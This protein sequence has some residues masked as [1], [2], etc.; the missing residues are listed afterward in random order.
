MSIQ[1]PP[2]T[3]VPCLPSRSLS[4]F[5][6]NGRTR[7]LTCSTSLWGF[8]AGDGERSAAGGGEVASSTGSDVRLGCGFPS[9]LCSKGSKHTGKEESLRN[10]KSERTMLTIS[11]VVHR[12]NINLTAV[13]SSNTG[14]K[15]DK[16]IPLN[17]SKVRIYQSCSTKMLKN[18][19][20]C[21][22]HHKF[23]FIL[24]LKDGHF[25]AIFA[26]GI[27]GFGLRFILRYFHAHGKTTLQVNW[28]LEDMPV[29]LLWSVLLF[30][31]S[32]C[33]SQP[34]NWRRPL[35]SQIAS[36]MFFS[37]SHYSVHEFIL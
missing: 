28:K 19:V 35:N 7:F 31:P 13:T 17:S 9:N 36:L 37:H 16:I 20:L 10:L 8:L 32:V 12:R 25:S 24:L 34:W 3:N 15:K 5:R 27:T 6:V 11:G 18:I 2:S 4:W 33:M 23:Q 14:G 30:S 26:S 1:N 21:L 22:W 29:V